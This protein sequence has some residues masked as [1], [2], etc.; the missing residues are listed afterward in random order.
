MRRMVLH[1]TLEQPVPTVC[2]TRPSP[3]LW[4]QLAAVGCKGRREL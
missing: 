2:P 3:P 1:L 4:R